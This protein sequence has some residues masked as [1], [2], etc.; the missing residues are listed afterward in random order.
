MDDRSNLSGLFFSSLDR[1]QTSERE[2]EECSIEDDLTPKQRQEMN[3]IEGLYGFATPNADAKETAFRHSGWQ[4][5]RKRVRIAMAAANVPSKRL[6][7]F[8]ACGA[9][10]IVEYSPSTCRQRVKAFYCGDRFC[11]P[12]AT[13]RS[14]RVQRKLS[15]LVAGRVS[16]F[17][18]LTL[19][20]CGG[21]LIERLNHLDGSFKRLRRSPL[22]KQAVDAGASVVEIKRGAGSGKWHVHLHSILLGRELDKY[23]L[24]REWRKATGDSFI[25]HVRKV[26]DHEKAVSYCAAYAGKGFDK[27]VLRVEDDL[28]ECLCSLRS[29]R[30]LKFFGGWYRLDADGDEKPIT[31]WRRVGRLGDFI[32]GSVSGDAKSMAVMRGLGVQVHRDD[33]GFYFSRTE[34]DETG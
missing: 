21:S 33:E 25:V 19:R 30:L 29:S 17:V 16:W 10:A 12:C 7:R 32:A 2:V 24:S 18:T 20:N 15:A 6:E 28:L 23:R 3:R 13:A 8:D 1:Q 26:D 27:S 5:D 22:W 9:E 31:D 34:P 4:T 11:V 14:R